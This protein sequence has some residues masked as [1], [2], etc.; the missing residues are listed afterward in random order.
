MAIGKKALFGPTA[1]EC[2][3]EPVAMTGKIEVA[4]RSLIASAIHW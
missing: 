1:V 2:K 3:R 4:I